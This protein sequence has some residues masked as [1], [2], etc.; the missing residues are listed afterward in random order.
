METSDGQL[1]VPPLLTKLKSNLYA[2]C[3]AY[4]PFKLYLFSSTTPVYKSAC[5]SRSRFTK[6]VTISPKK[7]WTISEVPVITPLSLSSSSSLLPN[8]RMAFLLQ[9]LQQSL[10]QSSTCGLKHIC[11]KNYLTLHITPISPLNQSSVSKLLSLI[12]SVIRML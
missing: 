4:Y 1:V 12:W 5:W 11:S 7:Y 6:R 9:S 2:L 8:S 3:S 10:S